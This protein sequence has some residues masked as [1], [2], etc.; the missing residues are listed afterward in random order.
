MTLPQA[1]PGWP[2]ALT[3][4]GTRQAQVPPNFDRRKTPKIGKLGLFVVE[5]MVEAA[6][7]RHPGRLDCLV[8]KP[9]HWPGRAFC[10]PSLLLRGTVQVGLTR[11]YVALTEDKLVV[12]C[13]P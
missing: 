10:L 9:G 1:G 11:N 8:C 5:R 4:P 2:Q 6:V 3:L 13:Y 12:Y 7:L